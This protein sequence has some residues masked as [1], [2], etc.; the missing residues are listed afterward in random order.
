MEKV[1][2]LYD[3]TWSKKIYQ[4][5][6][7]SDHW[8]LNNFT[9]FFRSGSHV[10]VKLVLLWK[11]YTAIITETFYSG[12]FF[13]RINKLLMIISVL[14]RRGI[15]SRE[16]ICINFWFSCFLGI[17]CMSTIVMHWHSL[18]KLIVSTVLLRLFR[19]LY[20]LRREFHLGHRRKIMNM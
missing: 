3:N 2:K 7:L 9:I 6:L 8:K 5:R 4:Y 11:R 20:T 1:K 13:L 17:I 10:L 16:S 15:C 18:I 14:F 12:G 19:N